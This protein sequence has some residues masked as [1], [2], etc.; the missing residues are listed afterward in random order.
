MNIIN[1]LNQIKEG[2]I[3]LPGIQRDFVWSKEKIVKLLDSIMR[4]YP[5]G[6]ALLWET[7][8]DIQYRLFDF[9]YRSGNLYTFH[10]NTEHKRLKLVLD[11][12]QRLQSLYIALYGKLDGEYLYFDVLSG[13]E[14]DNLA[15]EKYIF[16]FA[17][18]EEIKKR[19]AS[20]TTTLDKYIGAHGKDSAQHYYVKVA[21]IFKMGARQKKE[22]VR[23]LAK[24][25]ICLMRMNFALTSISLDLMKL[26][27]KMRTFLKH[28]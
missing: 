21:D 10:E 2:E 12:Q 25:S 6:I 7:Y 17:T 8:N 24:K 23:H 1:L 18:P 19:N 28:R 16:D 3:V 20:I 14:S 26:F 9:D 22:L 13:R 15:E 27:Q 4:G 11:G 5:I